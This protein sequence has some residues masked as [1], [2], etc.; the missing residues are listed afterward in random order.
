MTFAQV[1]DARSFCQEH[2]P[3]WVVLRALREERLVVAGRVVFHYPSEIQCWIPNNNV[4]PA[5]SNDEQGCCP[6][7]LSP[8]GL[9]HRK[10]KYMYPRG[11]A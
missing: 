1:E 5:V 8:V 9:H 11:D 3:V 2:L 10:W 6:S 7:D 4:C